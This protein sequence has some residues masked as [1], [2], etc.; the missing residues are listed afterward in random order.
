MLWKKISL[1]LLLLA[2]PLISHASYREPEKKCMEECHGKEGF[3]YTPASYWGNMHS[4]YVNYEKFIKSKHA[5]FTCLDC[6]PD[7]DA[8]EK[9]HTPMRKNVKCESCHGPEHLMP[10]HIKKTFKEKGIEMPE[11]KKVYNDYV[12]SV[13][14]RA[15]LQKK[16]NAPYCTGCHD[17][18]NA[19]KNDKDFAVKLDNLPKTCGKCH[20]DQVGKDKTVFSKMA[21]FRI[22]GHKKGNSATDFSIKN[23]VACHQGDSAHGKKVNEQ[24]C[25]DCHKRKSNLFATDF[26]GTE[27]P[28]LAILLNFGLVFCIVLIGGAVIVYKISGNESKKE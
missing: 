14:G 20:L 4:L 8:G 1:I 13:H 9:A 18:H 10:E 3:Y 27:L 24:V 15:Y 12:E 26:H 6:H 21:L 7:A 25:M 23:C 11:K 22:N 17:P 19:N 16:R 2:F 28:G 5:I